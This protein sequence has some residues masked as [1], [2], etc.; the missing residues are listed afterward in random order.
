MAL[1]ADLGRAKRF[2]FR[3]LEHGF[4][5]S[6]IFKYKVVAMLGSLLVAE[7]EDTGKVIG[8]GAFSLLWTG[9]GELVTPAIE[10]EHQREG[11]GTNIVKAL[12]DEAGRLKVPGVITLTCKPDFFRKLGF[13]LSGKNSFPRKLRRECLD[14]PKLEQCDEVVLHEA[15][16][17]V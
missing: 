11:I 6:R 2:Y 3:V 7:D 15:M 14:C 1:R 9:L 10:D 17:M 4:S 12:L 5:G 16:R 8:C 13:E